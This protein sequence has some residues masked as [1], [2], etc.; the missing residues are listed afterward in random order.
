MLSETETQFNDDFE[1]SNFA[2]VQ[3]QEVSRVLK[4]YECFR[5]FVLLTKTAVDLISED[6]F[7]VILKQ[8]GTYEI[9]FLSCMVLRTQTSFCVF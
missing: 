6:Q 4:R 8:M 9:N 2:V 3:L 5:F 1:V 7:Y